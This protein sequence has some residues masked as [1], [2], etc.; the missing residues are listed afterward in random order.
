[1]DPVRLAVVVVLVAAGAVLTLWYRRRARR[2][3]DPSGLPPLP[4]GLVDSAE[5]T[6]V[7][8]TTPYCVSCGAIE[9]RLRRTEPESHIVL[10]DAS[11][12]PDLAARYRVRRAPTVLLAGADGRVQRSFVGADAVGAFLAGE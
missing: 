4:S 2:A 8:F 3:P 10:V 9:E 5:R 11:A 6:W 7:V 12:D 1:M